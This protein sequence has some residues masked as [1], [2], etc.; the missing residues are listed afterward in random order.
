MHP[1]SA[2]MVLIL[3]V[4]RGSRQLTRASFHRGSVVRAALSQCSDGATLLF[5][6]L[7]S[8]CKS[9][10]DRRWTLK[11]AARSEQG[12]TDSPRSLALRRNL[13]VLAECS[14]SHN[15]EQIG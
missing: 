8:C 13:V 3:R 4:A 14:S 2:S 7:A 9:P 6:G 15:Q 12:R 5:R 11:G 1:N 10:S